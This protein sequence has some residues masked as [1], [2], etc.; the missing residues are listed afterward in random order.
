MGEK[1]HADFDLEAFSQLTPVRNGGVSARNI[2]GVCKRLLAQPPR[3]SPTF[4][5]SFARWLEPLIGDVS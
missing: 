5:A 1:I 3:R 2:A 4:K